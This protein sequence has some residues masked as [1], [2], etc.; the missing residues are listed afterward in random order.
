MQQASVLVK[1]GWAP[2]Y[3]IKRLHESSI[4]GIIASVA[5]LQ[6]FVIKRGSAMAKCQI[7]G[8]GPQFGHSVSH[9]NKATNR[10]WKPNI[11]KMTLVYQGKR[12]RMNVCSRCARTLHKAR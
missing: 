12:Q 4:Y 7:C 9:S 1:L 2:K 5:L 8:K 3:S 11:Q 6:S 10:Q